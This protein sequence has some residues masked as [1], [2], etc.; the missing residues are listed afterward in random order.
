[1]LT[2]FRLILLLIISISASPTFG[3]LPSD[4]PIDGFTRLDQQFVL[5][6]AGPSYAIH[7]TDNDALANRIKG[8]TDD[9]ILACTPDIPESNSD[10]TK[11]LIT[12]TVTLSLAIGSVVWA[13]SSANLGLSKLI[14]VSNGEF[15]KMGKSLTLAVAIGVTIYL[16]MPKF[17]GSSFV[18]ANRI[19]QLFQSP[20][21]AE[22]ATYLPPSPEFLAVRDSEV[23]DMGYQTNS[24]SEFLHFAT[25]VVT[26]M[27]EAEGSLLINNARVD[28]T[29]DSVIVELGHSNNACYLR[30]E[31]T[32]N[33]YTATQIQKLDRDG[34]EQAVERFRQVEQNLMVSSVM[35]AVNQTISYK[36][37]Q[38]DSIGLAYTIKDNDLEMVAIEP[39]WYAS[40]PANLSEIVEVESGQRSEITT[41]LR[42]DRL[43]ELCLSKSLVSKWYAPD[44]EHT[45]KRRMYQPEPSG[46]TLYDAAFELCRVNA[47]AEQTGMFDC[48]VAMDALEHS[49]YLDRINSLG[50]MVRPLNTYSLL[51]R[52]TAPVEPQQS[53]AKWSFESEFNESDS[54]DFNDNY[55]AIR[56]RYREATNDVSAGRVPLFDLVKQEVESKGGVADILDI[57]G[58]NTCLTTPNQVIYKS[59]GEISKLCGSPLNTLSDLGGTMIKTYALLQAGH[60][61]KGVVSK[62]G[63]KK[64]KKGKSKTDGK[65]SSKKSSGVGLAMF[66]GLFGGG[67]IALISSGVFGS[68]AELEPFMHSPSDTLSL[69]GSTAA[70]VAGAALTDGML[71]MANFLLLGGIALKFGIPLMFIVPFYL[72]LMVVLV[73]LLHLSC[74]LVLVMVQ[75]LIEMK[76]VGDKLLGVMS[77]LCLLLLY[78]CCLPLLY[79]LSIIL[80]ETLLPYILGGVGQ[81]AENATTATGSL[82]AMLFAVVIYSLLYV[83]FVI[84]L[85]YKSIEVY[86]AGWEFSKTLFSDA[87]ASSLDNRV[88]QGSNDGAKNVAKSVVSK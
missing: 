32:R 48:A 25:C 83:A 28:G 35:D 70:F 27:E 76:N 4:C 85:F 47:E 23:D 43:A 46:E 9:E 50:W 2:K 7:F 51:K 37:N 41:L 69:L 34:G 73:T 20:T 86:H 44:Y 72:M 64:T 17:V 80:S 49:D 36:R 62:L 53:L 18:A 33:I 57:S 40:C 12:T 79:Y 16:S 84:M 3:N 71:S 14:K 68:A 13:F 5:A 30:S 56:N 87:G 8:I 6:V 54:G 65:I 82:S 88:S 66:G 11:I 58:V 39:D 1:M 21:T 78:I 24:M 42:Q 45:G 74:Q 38:F 26:E 63:M 67:A 61:A 31:M 55:R 59:N 52:N 81:L 75:P 29:G 77:R 15:K 60:Y 10:I 22:M 19:D